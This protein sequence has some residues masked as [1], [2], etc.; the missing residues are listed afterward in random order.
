MLVTTLVRCK[1]TSGTRTSNTQSATRSSRPIGSRISGGYDPP[2]FRGRE[3]LPGRWEQGLISRRFRTM[4]EGHHTRKAGAAHSLQQSHSW[5]EAIM[6]SSFTQLVLGTAAVISMSLVAVSAISN[7]VAQA[8]PKSD[9]VIVTEVPSSETDFLLGDRQQLRSYFFDGSRNR[10]RSN[11]RPLQGQPRQGCRAGLSGRPAGE[12]E[13]GAER[14][15]STRPRHSS[16]RRPWLA[17]ADRALSRAGR[18]Q[19]R[20]SEALGSP[21]VSGRLALGQLSLP[22][23][24]F[25]GALRYL[26]KRSASP[27]RPS[28]GLRHA[29]PCAAVCRA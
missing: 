12:F 9:E 16:R 18:W 23:A 4:C 14:E 5:M 3:T 6:Q 29:R 2:S 22:L 19:S 10:S 21:A 1:R 17:W 13:E 7:A 20:I 28:G 8:P 27:A 11:R 15:R 25:E 26:F 24:A